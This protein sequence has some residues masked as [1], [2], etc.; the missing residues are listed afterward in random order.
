M[1]PEVWLAH[2]HA[3]VVD[4]QDLVF[5]AALGDTVGRV[6]AVVI[7]ADHGHLAAVDGVHAGVALKVPSVEGYE[8]A[9]S[10]DVPHQIQDHQT[11]CTPILGA[12]AKV[13]EAVGSR[14]SEGGW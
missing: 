8:P 1:S 11:S 2:I 13:Q 6:L 9:V 4:V 14:G 7:Q 3:G 12:L 10:D 5:R